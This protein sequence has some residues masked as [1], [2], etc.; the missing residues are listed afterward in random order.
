MQVDAGRQVFTTRAKRALAL[1]GVAILVL[2]GSAAAYLWRSADHTNSGPPP[3]PTSRPVLVSMT[4]TSER[5]AWLIV[6]DS[7]GPESFLF[8]TGDGGD[9]WQR[10]LSINGLGVLRFADARRGVLLNY[11]LGL[12]PEAAIPRAFATTDAGAHWLPVAM[13]RLNLGF[14]ADPFF[15]DPD[16]AWVLG[17]RAA[18]RDGPVAEEHI[19]WR[20]R[21]GG[22]HWEQLLRVDAAQPI[23]HGLSGRDLIAGITFRDPDTGWMVTLGPAE[24]AGV[25]VTHNGGRDW[26][27]SA[28]AVAPPGST[29]QHWLYL[30]P[31]LVSGDGKGMMSVLDR[32]LVQFFVLSTADGGESWAGPQSA[33]AAG[34]LNTA[35]VNGSV[36]WVA[37]GNGAWVTAD[38]GR[39]W[40]KSAALP[41]GMGLGDVAPVDASLVW[42]QGRKLGADS[43]PT[44][45]VLFRTSDGGKHW[46]PVKAPSLG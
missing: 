32:D 40:L 14:N 41:G 21:D 22:R 9:H 42:V 27:R 8:H 12:Q 28:I 39:S 44:S 17:T 2:A 31:L 20:T 1:I 34:S 5:Q 3:P 30:G 18:S 25:Y 36:A 16:R 45:W 26:T 6:H 33:P 23:D 10:Q 11:Q 46:R 19:L 43:N 4:A 13:P 35:F 38:S 15:L 7:G 29:G 37:N 24:S